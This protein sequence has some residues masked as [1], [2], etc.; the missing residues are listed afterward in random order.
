MRL[1]R[2]LAGPPKFA[3]EDQAYARKVQAALGIE[4]KGMS[5][6]ITP[7]SVPRNDGFG[8]SGTDVG[9]VSWNAPVL[10]LTAA[11]QV[12]G[13]PGHSW[14]IVCTGSMS[15]GHKG[16][17]TAA[18]TLSATVLDLLMEPNL[19]AEVR[20]E[21]REKTQGKPYRNPLPPDAKPPVVPKPRR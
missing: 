12:I 6:V 4:Q 9:E 15:I 17:L 20:A 19:L 16:M 8:G 18:R 3:P 10:R 14:A 2:R 7:L 5:D 1:W 11:T 13:S 21:W